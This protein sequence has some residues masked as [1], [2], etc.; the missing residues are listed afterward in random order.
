MTSR[1]PDLSSVRPLGYDVRSSNYRKF[2]GYLVISHVLHSVTGVAHKVDIY[3]ALS[4]IRISS[5]KV[6]D[7]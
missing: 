2:F 1:R 5:N 4:T 3:P 7:N 6:V